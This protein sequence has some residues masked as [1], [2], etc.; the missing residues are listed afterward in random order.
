MRRWLWAAMVV[1]ILVDAAVFA[2][3]MTRDQLFSSLQN[4]ANAVR[5]KTILWC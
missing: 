2:L 3:W 4:I 5:V 1:L